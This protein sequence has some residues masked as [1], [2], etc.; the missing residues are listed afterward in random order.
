VPKPLLIEIGC[1]EIPARVVGPLAR[2][3]AE[4]LN[5]HLK[6]AGLAEQDGVAQWTP[7][8]LI[9]LNDEVAEWQPER[10]EEILGPPKK[11]AVAADGSFTPQA[12]GFAARN[13]LPVSAL[14]WQTTPKGDYVAAKRKTGGG[15]APDLLGALIPQALLEIQ[16]PRAMRW[17]DSGVRFIRPIRW[18]LACL[19]DQ[20]VPFQIGKLKSCMESRGHRSLG[21]ARFPVSRCTNYPH[22]WQ[23]NGVIPDPAQRR[24]QIEQKAELVRRDEDLLDTLVNLTEYPDTITGEFD[25]AYLGSLPQDVLVT[26]MRDHQKYFAVNDDSGNLAARFVAVINQKGDPRGLIRHGNE[27]VLKARFSDAQFFWEQDRKMGLGERLALLEQVTF[28]VKLGSY[29]QKSLRMRALAEWLA[30]QWQGQGCDAG[31]AV[32]AAEL[33]KCDLTTEMVK[34]F[35]ELQGIMG[36]HYARAEGQPEAIAMAIADQY[37]WDAPPRTLEGA[38]VS[39]ADKFDTI[40]GM[41]AIGEIPSGSADPFGLR[42]Q[43]NGIVRTLIEKALPLSLSQTCYRA[44]AGYA[45]QADSA[46]LANFFRE[47]LFFYLSEN[48]RWSRPLVAAVLA[49]GADNPLDA[50]ARCRA[51]ASAPEAAAVAAVVKRARN[52]VRKENWTGTAVDPSRLTASA[53]E[54]LYA[55]VKGLDR[56]DSD[57]AAE[58]AAIGGLAA[59]LEQFFAEVRVND[60]NPAVRA[61]RLALLAWTVE[62]LTRIADFSEFAAG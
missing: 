47:R 16:L 13:G 18:L 43:A 19:D 38:A 46:A 37:A 32:I 8:R 52:I 22:R 17:D 26:V 33:A 23:D 59:P 57:Y 35:T 53:E 10:E 25:A 21:A 39:L 56:A 29:R 55:A 12:V 30:K 5:R 45:L 41:F 42:R 3:F 31:V 15:A 7:R 24:A 48:G 44:L 2:Q 14:Y 34:E 11:V 36:G 27:R 4:N 28:Q 49:A 20:L 40:A 58:L 62:R 9:Y 6:S 50:A 61:N 54:A 60:E 1:E 51:V